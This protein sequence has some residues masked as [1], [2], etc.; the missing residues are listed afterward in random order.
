[1]M[2]A[3]FETLSLASEPSQ[4]K[5]QR[6]RRLKDTEGPPVPQ[7]PPKA[8]PPSKPEATGSEPQ[9]GER[10]PGASSKPCLQWLTPGGCKFGDKCRFV[11]NLDETAMK[12]R[13]FVCSAEGHWANQC[14]FKQGHGPDAKSEVAEG[15]AAPKDG[16]ARGKGKPSG[17]GVPNPKM[18][19]VEGPNASGGLASSVPPVPDATAGAEPSATAELAKE[20][21]EVLKSL[22]L[23]LGISQ[24]VVVVGDS[25]FGLIDSGATA[26]LRQGSK[27]ELA[28]AT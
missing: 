26:A 7:V 2:L 8:D 5:R 21:S 3:E 11:H 12:E 9:A 20:M 1:M 19:A 22:R 17:K 18:K 4:A 16:K 13:C 15:V 28:V 23:K 6:V 10:P 14:P 27:E 24:M 25:E